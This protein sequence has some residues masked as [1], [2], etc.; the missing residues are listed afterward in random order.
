VDGIIISYRSKHKKIVDGKTTGPLHQETWYGKLKDGSGNFAVRKSIESLKEEDVPK[1][2]DKKIRE[3]LKGKDKEEIKKYAEEN[4]IKSLRLHTQENEDSLMGVRDKEGKIYKY[5]KT[6][7]NYCADIYCPN[8][9]KSKGQWQTEIISIYDAHQKNFVPQWR[10]DEPEA[11]LIMRLAMDDMVEIEFDKLGESIQKRFLPYSKNGKI[12]TKVKKMTNN[13]VYLR[14]DLVA[15][16]DTDK[17]S[18][19]ASSKALQSANA[20]KIRVS[21]LGEITYLKR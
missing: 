3:D 8:R 1:I 9:G 6:Y 19:G 7:G 14:P 21:P 4:H 10:K 18:Y 16:E 15:K 13:L 2:G 11:K 17:L 12:I 5:A 20:K